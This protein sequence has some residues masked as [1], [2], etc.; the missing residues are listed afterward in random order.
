MIKIGTPVREYDG[1]VYCFTRPANDSATYA[2]F[3]TPT[4]PI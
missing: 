4:R 3:S 2:M 1:K